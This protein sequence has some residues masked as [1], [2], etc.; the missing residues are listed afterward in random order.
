MGRVAVRK[1]TAAGARTGAAVGRVAG[2]ALGS[3][4]PIIG[5]AIGGLAGGAI[6]GAIGGA[7]GAAVDAGKFAAKNIGRAAK[8][9]A[10]AAKKNPLNTAGLVQGAQAQQSANAEANKQ[11]SMQQTQ[12]AAQRGKEISTGTTT[13]SQYHYADWVL[14]GPMHDAWVI[15]KESMP[16]TQGYP[17][18]DPDTCEMCN[19][20]KIIHD[21]AGGGQW[22]YCSHCEGT[23]I[24]PPK[25]EFGYAGPMAHSVYPDMP[26]F[27]ES[28]Q[29]KNASEPMKIAFRLL[30]ARMEIGPHDE[31]QD[32]LFEHLKNINGKHSIRTNE[33]DNSFMLDDVHDD[34]EDVVRRLIGSYGRNF[35]DGKPVEEKPESKYF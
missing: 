20:K 5:T 19:G 33:E 34:D 27:A 15:L 13:K 22:H 1:A 8:T 4:V 18:D 11:A 10:K 24:E 30:K 35:A 17:E 3:F 26:G 9:G 23:G 25:G 32:E 6:G 2:A 14:D 16:G 31:Q 12:E 21:P 7:G 29:E 28:W